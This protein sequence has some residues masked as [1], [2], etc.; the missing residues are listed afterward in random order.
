M[1]PSPEADGGVRDD[2]AGHRLVVEEVGALAE[3]VYDVSQPGRMVLVHTGVPKE[4]GGRGVGGRLV[5][6]AVARARA[7]HLTIVAQ[8]PFARRWLEGHRDEVSGVDI[9]WPPSPGGNT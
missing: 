1:T 6:A 3:L 4:L 9:D 5:Q 8:C 2:L 7:E